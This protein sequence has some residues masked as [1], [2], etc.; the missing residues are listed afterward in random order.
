MRIELLYPTSK[1]PKQATDGSGGF[2]LYLPHNI[3]V[4]E[5]PQLI[6]LGIR[7]EIPKGFVALVVPRSGV[8]SEHGIELE[9]SVGVIDADYRGEWFAKLRVKPGKPMVSFA[10][11][12]RI[13]QFLLVPV[14][15]P[16]LELVDCV[17][18]TERGVGGFGSTG[19]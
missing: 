4:D 3:V 13:L 12:D 16:T 19:A 5:N 7:T 17:N 10:K 14:A 6:P 18:E 8:G 11:E 15:T 9:N 2:D 1:M